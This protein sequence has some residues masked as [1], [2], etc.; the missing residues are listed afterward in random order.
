MKKLASGAEMMEVGDLVITHDR[1]W[2]VGLVNV[3]RA[4]LDPVTPAGNGRSDWD[5]M[6]VG[7]TSLVDS[8]DDYEFDERD[9]ARLTKMLEDAEF[10]ELLEE[11]RRL[12]AQNR[13]IDRQERERVERFRNTPAHSAVFG[14]PETSDE[15][16]GNTMA[17][18]EAPVSKPSAA[19]T[20]KEKNAKRLADLKAKKAQQAEA[21]KAEGGKVAKPP[22]EKK[23]KEPKACKCG[24]GGTTNGYFVPGHDAKFKGMLLQI[25]K[26]KA[27]KEDVLDA[28]VIAEYKWVKAA[29]G[30]QRPTTN[31]KGEPHEGYVT[32][33]PAE[34]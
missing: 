9:I 12:T 13:E 11:E 16:E 25:E 31:Y 30:G 32:A 10:E 14:S 23:V 24:C 5:S 19:Q 20:L 1:V 15:G 26:G 18:A 17:V 4:R 2:R 27:K 29:A 34:E 22:R 8:G 33:A 6:D 21:K 3:S 7:P 28:E